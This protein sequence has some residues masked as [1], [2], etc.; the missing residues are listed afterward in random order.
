MVD[1]EDLLLLMS[2]L[3]EE[4]RFIADELRPATGISSSTSSRT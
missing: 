3:I 2:G 4:H 1:F